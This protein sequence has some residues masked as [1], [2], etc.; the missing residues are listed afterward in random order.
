MMYVVGNPFDQARNF[1]TQ[2]ETFATKKDFLNESLLNKH[3][4]FSTKN[5]TFQLRLKP[6][7]NLVSLIGAVWTP[8]YVQGTTKT[9]NITKC[10]NK[11]FFHHSE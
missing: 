3:G 8:F 11:K 2:T 1:L 6:S 9:E 5:E 7:Y 4:T 10:V